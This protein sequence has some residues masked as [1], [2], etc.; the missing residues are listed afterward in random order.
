[1]FLNSFTNFLNCP[2]YAIKKKKFV[3]KTIIVDRSWLEKATNPLL[4]MALNFIICEL[5]SIPIFKTLTAFPS[6]DDQI[7]NFPR[8]KSVA[9]RFV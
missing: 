1:M 6:L 3:N 2:N 8:L 9:F 7:L 4:L 5:A